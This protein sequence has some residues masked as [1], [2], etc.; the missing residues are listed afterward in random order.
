M[1][2]AS[3]HAKK[4]G[5]SRKLDKRHR[6]LNHFPVIYQTPAYFVNFMTILLQSADEIP[7]SFRLP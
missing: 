5:A 4:W 6:N 2:R 1:P 7:L 3:H